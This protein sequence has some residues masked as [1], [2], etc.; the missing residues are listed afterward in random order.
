MFDFFLNLNFLPPPPSYLLKQISYQVTFYFTLTFNK[1][2]GPV[3]NPEIII[4]PILL[5]KLKY[6]NR[7]AYISTLFSQ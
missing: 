5:T 6:W 2:R 4:V 3:T 7:K 1:Y